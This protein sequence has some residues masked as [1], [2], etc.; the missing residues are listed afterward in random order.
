M[1]L[2]ISANYLS[3]ALQD[4]VQIGETTLR[5]HRVADLILPTRKL[6]ACDPFVSPEAEPFSL[7]VPRGTFSVVLSVAEIATDQRVAFA[8]V[9]FKQT[10]PVKWEMMA[11]GKNNP[12]ELKAGHM[13]GY[14][15]DS[16]TGCFMGSSAGDVLTRKMK[17]QDN[18]FETMMA[19]M[20]KTYRHTWSWLNMKFGDSNLVAFSSGYGDGL[21]ATYAGLDRQGDVAVVVTDFMVLDDDKETGWRSINNLFTRLRLRLRAGLRRKE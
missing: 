13:F 5:H 7:L 20:E 11:S 2:P 15:V 6:V 3:L 8:T 17:E 14:G 10:P 12:S 4:G 18:F 16:A 1:I 19:E 21:N 9:R